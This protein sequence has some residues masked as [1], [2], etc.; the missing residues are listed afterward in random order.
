MSRFSKLVES[1]ENLHQEDIKNSAQVF[2]KAAHLSVR[3]QQLIES[4]ADSSPALP[5]GKMTQAEAIARYGNYNNAYA[6]Y[7]KAYGIKCRKGWS[8]FLNA[9]DGLTPPAT[10]EE[11]VTQLETTV[12]A[13]V[14]L[15]IDGINPNMIR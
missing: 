9:I 4:L 12:Q 3:L 15:L 11:R 1:L 7:Q 8:N 2:G 5:S 6:A 10:L 13:L 14:E